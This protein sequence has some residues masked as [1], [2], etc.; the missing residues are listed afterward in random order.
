MRISLGPSPF[1]WG[2]NGFKNYYRKMAFETPVD[3]LYLGEV[4]CSK[5]QSLSAREMVELARELAPSGK[6]IVFSTLGL[7]MN[8]AEEEL[9]HQVAA[10]AASG[11]WWLEANDMGGIAVGEGT[12][13]VAGPHITTYN[14]ETVDFLKKVGVRRVVYPVELSAQ[15]IGELIARQGDDVEGEVF[16]Y[17][18]LPLTF[19]ARC[20]TARAFQ[21]SKSNCQYRCGDFPD[22]LAMRTQEGVPFL[23]INGT[24]TLSHRIYNLVNEVDRLERM[25]VGVI[26]LSPQSE[27]MEEI[28]TVWHERLQRRIGDEEAWRRLLEIN[29]GVPFCNGYFHGRSGLEYV[30]PGVSPPAIDAPVG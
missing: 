12:P 14:P 6:E 20:Y 5:R 3:L 11:G 1:D 26:R 17:G 8:A 15:A 16:C 27:R 10:A 21:L 28:V 25:G 29:G 4:V 18:K 2:K 22:G 23:S 9:L 30:E 7:V 24:Q 13:M 19:S